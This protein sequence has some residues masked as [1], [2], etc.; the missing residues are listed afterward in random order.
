MI[1][2]WYGEGCFKFQNGDKTVLTDIPAKDSGISAPKSKP[3]ILIK[4]IVSWPDKSG[5]F[6]DA[7]VVR[8]A[9]EYDVRGIKIRG[10]EITE[11]SSDVFFKTVY[12]LNWDGINIGLLGTINKN[13]SP[14]IL[15]KF[16]NLDILI[17]PGGG[18]PFIEQ[19]DISHMIKQLNPKIFIPSFFKIK[20]LK[21]KAG[22]VKSLVGLFNGDAQTDQEKLVVKKKD[23]QDIKKTKLICLKA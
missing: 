4:T 11:E 1:I 9:G 15:E 5:D 6:R 18:A 19:K 17:A 13:P 21:R 2:S 3:N 22:D 8:G 7:F 10:E 14:Q 12:V 20:N 16:E 23:F